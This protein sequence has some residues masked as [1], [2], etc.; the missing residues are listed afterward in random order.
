MG[1][2]LGRGKTIEEVLAGMD[3]VAEGVKSA[4]VVVELGRKHGVDLPI[5]EEV[6]LVIEHGH[7]AEQ[8]YRGLLRRPHQG[9]VKRR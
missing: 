7:T 3:Q 4:P 6:Q 5:A 1:E 9:E 8:A 2:A